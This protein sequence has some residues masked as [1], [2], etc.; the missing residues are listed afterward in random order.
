MVANLSLAQMKIELGKPRAN[1]RTVERFTRDAAEAG[2]KLILLPELWSSGY[3]LQHAHEHAHTNLGILEEVKALALEYRIGIGGSLL[4]QE[5]GG[6]YNCFVLV[7]EDGQELGRYHKVHLFRLMQED[8][9]LQ[10]GQRAQMAQTPFGAAGMAVCYDLRFPE[11]FRRYALD[12]ARIILLPAEWPARRQEHWNILLRARAIENQIFVAAVNT[13]GE[14]GAETF[15]GGSALISPWGEVLAS[16]GA[17]ETLLHAEIDPAQVQA[18]R[19][20]IPI[21]PDRRPEIYD[22]GGK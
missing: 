8:Q 21:F 19:E 9:Y 3:D 17:E 15:A 13:T 2:S 20:R 6:V 22:L 16:A 12:G 5:P 1:L 14:I 11:L 18:A 4:L 7:G 10:A